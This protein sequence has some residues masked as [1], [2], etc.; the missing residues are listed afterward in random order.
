MPANATWKLAIFDCDGV[1]V[2]SEAITHQ[3]LIDALGELG[4]DLELE[5]ALDLF[6]GNTL[7]QTVTIIEEQLGRPLP[8][9]FFPE[10]RERLYS[11]LRE[12]PVQSVPGV[13]QVLDGLSCP[14]C[15]V[16]NGPFR[17]ME[18]TL[19]TTGLLARFEGRLFSPEAGLQGKP[20]PD[21]FLAAAARFGVSPSQTFVVEDSPTGV[22]GAVAAR[23]TVFGYAGAAHTDALALEREGAHVFSHMRDLPALLIE[24]G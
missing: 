9:N 6:V 8:A 17:K 10:W 11:T 22:R 12:L 13:Q 4:L 2:D 19:G 20:A 21:L 16:S 5:Q 3:V 23:M 24:H 18:T 7:V 1:L 15:V 14:A